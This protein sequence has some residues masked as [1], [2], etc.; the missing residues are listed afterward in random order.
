ME[1]LQ[2]GQVL[3]TGELLN[4]C[5]QDRSGAWRPPMYLDTLLALQK[6]DTIYVDA[7][8]H[9]ENFWVLS[10]TNDSSIIGFRTKYPAR[11]P[12]RKVEEQT[13][14]FHVEDLDILIITA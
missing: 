9:D 12:F 6:F 7:K 10:S 11:M 1:N 2:A 5:F 14:G 4:L 13:P 8:V 3:K